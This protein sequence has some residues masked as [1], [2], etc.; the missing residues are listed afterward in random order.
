[1]FCCLYSWMSCTG[2]KRR[3]KKRHRTQTSAAGRAKIISWG[4][5]W[6]KNMNRQTASIHNSTRGSEK[7]NQR[8]CITAAPTLWMSPQRGTSTKGPTVQRR[9]NNHTHTHKGPHVCGEIRQS[10]GWWWL[11]HI[12]MP[13]TVVPVRG[14]STSNWASVTHAL[15]QSSSPALACN[16]WHIAEPPTG[17]LSPCPADD[18]GDDGRG[19]SQGDRF[20]LIEWK[21]R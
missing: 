2:G 13:P 1:M 4:L 14:Q 20:C 6:C 10:K 12:A 17:L 11:W 21:R 9:K 16:V 15:C 5:T 8:H 19:T 7:M 18:D 3:G